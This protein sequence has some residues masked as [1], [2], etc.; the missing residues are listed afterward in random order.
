MKQNDRNIEN[1]EKDENYGKHIK[2]G[3]L[4]TKIE[5]IGENQE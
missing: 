5:V 3:K 1:M 2:E 4:K